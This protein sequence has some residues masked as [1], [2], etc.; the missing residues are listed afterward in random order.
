MSS[1]LSP[2]G[3]EEGGG[4]REEGEVGG[5]IPVMSCSRVSI[6]MGREGGRRREGGREGGRRREG[7]GREEGGGGGREGGR[8][9]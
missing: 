7:G 6:C 5:M 9:D 3:G 8:G 2:E 1:A 4:L